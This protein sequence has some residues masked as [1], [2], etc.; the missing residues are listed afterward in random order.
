MASLFPQHTLEIAR[1]TAVR[2]HRMDFERVLSLPRRSVIDCDRREDGSYGV[3]AQALC[4][5]VTD[6]Y[7]LPPR[8]NCKCKELGYPK[9]I[10]RLNPAQA[11]ALREVRKQEGG[12]GLLGT[13]SGKTMLS[14]LVALA[15]RD[16]KVAVL[17][18]K[19]D[20]RIHY[21]NA[22]QRLREHFRVPSFTFD[23]IEDGYG[24][25]VKSLPGQPAVPA[26]HFVPYTLLQN[27]KSTVLLERMAPD[28]IIC[29]EAHSVSSLDSTRTN[30]LRLYLNNHPNI[31]FCAWSG[32]L[33]KKSIKDQA[34]LMAWALGLGSPMPIDPDDVAAWAQVIDKGYEPDTETVTAQKIY[35][36]FD[37]GHRGPFVN[38]GIQEGFGQWVLETPGVIST[39]E[40]SADCSLVIHERK[41][42]ELPAEV[43]KALRDV[44]ELMKRPDGEELTEATEIVETARDIANGFYHYWA[45]PGI[46][47]ECEPG[48]MLDE[49]RCKH[50]QFILEWYRRRAAWNGEMRAR[51]ARFEPYLD[52]M[53]NVDDAARRAHHGCDCG[54]VAAKKEIPIGDVARHIDPRSGEMCPL[55][56]WNSGTWALWQEIADQVAYEPRVKWI[57][58][59][60]ARDAAEWAREHKGIVWTQSTEFGQ[61]V[62]E[63]AGINYHEGG[64]DAEQRILSEKGDRSIVASVKAH[65]TGRDGLQH[66]F[67]KQYF[68]EPIASGDLTQQVLGRLARPGQEAD[69]VESWVARH[70]SEVRD[71]FANAMR[72]AQFI[73]SLK[74][75]K[76]FLLAAD[77]TFDW[78]HA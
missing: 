54:Y 6:L 17:L 39:R 14:I 19:P 46:P 4:E 3:D 2:E 78:R 64:D 36:V 1:E 51:R 7:A 50:C 58:D 11:W 53:A 16:C 52:S 23:R 22:Y 24:A 18:A 71:A 40:T 27:Q 33:I 13:G 59:F 55:P 72:E 29:D 5:Y 60:F 73:E 49:M 75:N 69:T 68:C 57:S 15:V 21:W 31:R 20:Q 38:S 67:F 65:G 47:C 42:V 10:T 25:I 44:R 43:K 34:H 76:Q 26:L 35:K 41:K 8:T 74:L 9:C 77:I 45:F 12:V 61:K 30:R 63:L 32:T 70:S 62:A 37:T 48:V 66:R 56:M 28:L